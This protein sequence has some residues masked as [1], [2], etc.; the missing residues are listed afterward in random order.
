MASGWHQARV[1]RSLLLLAQNCCILDFPAAGRQSTL[2][3]AND[4][5]AKHQPQTYKR[6]ANTPSR[7]QLS[8]MPGSPSQHVC[9]FCPGPIFVPFPDSKWSV[10]FQGPTIEA[11]VMSREC[12]CVS[13][14]KMHMAG[15]HNVGSQLCSVNRHSMEV[16]YH[17]H[18]MN[19]QPLRHNTFG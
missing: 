17:S 4:E 5:T 1:R 10:P 9:G 11:M 15:C 19:T 16:P 6:G 2:M 14:E 18:H 13:I 8:I 3:S 7:V 12:M